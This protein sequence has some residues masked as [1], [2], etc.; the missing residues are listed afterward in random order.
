MALSANS[1]PYISYYDDDLEVLKVANRASG[2]WT[3]E[4]VEN[5]AGIGEVSSLVFDNSDNLH[6]AYY[7][8]SLEAVKYG[9]STPSGWD[10]Q[11]VHITYGAGDSFSMV[12]DSF[13]Y[14]HLAYSAGW[15]ENKA[16]R[17]ARKTAQGWVYE[18]AY[19]TEYFRHASLVLDSNESPHISFFD[20]QTAEFIYAW[21]SDNGWIT[22]TVDTNGHYRGINA[23]S[24]NSQDVPHLAYFVET[25]GFNECSLRFAT[26]TTSGWITQTL[27]SEISGS[28]TGISIS[29]DRANRP[30]LA[31]GLA[32]LWYGWDNGSDWTFEQVDQYSSGKIALTLDSSD[33][34][35][36]SYRRD[37]NLIYTNNESGTWSTDTVDDNP[38]TGFNS[39]LALDKDGVPHISYFDRGNLT[40]M[41]ASQTADGWFIESSPQS[42]CFSLGHTT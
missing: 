30:H 35:H 27:K 9:L 16:L 34:A 36:V 29:M 42:T 19:H 18:S 33:H 7:D 1:V 40:Y 25:A 22:E 24:V 37:S 3:S 15:S 32:G 17:Y 8:A 20:D 38:D 28:P 21:R 39:S 10:I 12:L 14:P 5:T 13:D 31:Y 26:R 2:S 4:L 23:L 6:I 41:Y 11:I